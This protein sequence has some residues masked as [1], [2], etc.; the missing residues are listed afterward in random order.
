MER[1]AAPFSP[2]LQEEPAPW[3]GPPVEEEWCGPRVQ[4]PV[5]LW[6]AGCWGHGEN[7]QRMEDSAWAFPLCS[8]IHSG[9][10][11]CHIFT[12]NN[13]S[14][15][16]YCTHTAYSM[17]TLCILQPQ[18][19]LSKMLKEK[20]H[21]WAQETHSSNYWV[22]PIRP[23]SI[24]H[25]RWEYPLHN[26]VIFRLAAQSVWWTCRFIMTFCSLITWQ[27]LFVG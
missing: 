6:C 21:C 4:P 8:W 16:C 1:H 27:S 20:K 9:E 7:G 22:I 18:T 25:L 15:I 10:P 12:N 5:W 13:I 24:K 19:A 23:N 26:P 2:D 3:R 14:S 11:V 17:R